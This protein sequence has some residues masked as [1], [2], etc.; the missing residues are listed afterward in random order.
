MP[1]SLLTN[2][3]AL[4]AQR[5]LENTQ[6]KLQ[7]SYERLASGTQINHPG[8]DPSGSV[9]VAAL[10]TQISATQQAQRNALDA[11][12]LVQV[13]EGG[14]NEI[15]NL[16]LRLRE[17]AVLSASD[18]VNDES[19]NAV[20]AESNELRSEIDRIANST[21]YFKTNLLNGQG[22]DLNFQIGTDNSELGR[23]GYAAGSINVQSSALGLDDVTLSDSNSALESLA[24]ID[25]ALSQITDARSRTGSF[26]T[27]LDS[28][29]NQ[30]AM[31]VE[32]LSGDVSRIRDTDYA[33]ETTEYFKHQAI[34]RAGIAVLAQANSSND[35][36]MRL[37]D[38]K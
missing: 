9:R 3:P 28:I 37:L 24:T 11:K 17:L 5:D 2:M 33:K 30:H 21:R 4:S 12:S 14:L 35:M 19:R 31:M 32:T 23:I 38:L 25:K 18:T 10:E 8:D 27:R 15:N 34:Q 26:Q 7:K 1:I 22:K 20:Q 13:A 6:G 16:T 29:S 36:V